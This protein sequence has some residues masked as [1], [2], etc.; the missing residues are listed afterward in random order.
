MVQT[1][2]TKRYYSSTTTRLT[3]CSGPKID[4][5]DESS[6]FYPEFTDES[7]QEITDLHKNLIDIIQNPLLKKNNF[8]QTKHYKKVE[9]IIEQ[10]LQGKRFTP[11][12][13]HK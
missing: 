12:P 3:K 9:E 1:P 6:T 5:F 8:M 13:V 2:P 10:T 4:E 7:V 11:R